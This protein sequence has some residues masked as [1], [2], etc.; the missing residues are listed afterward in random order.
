MGNSWQA[1]VAL[2]PG[3]H[4]ITPS[5]WTDV[6]L[7]AGPALTM[8]SNI[9]VSERWTSVANGRVVYNLAVPSEGIY[10]V[11]MVFVEMWH[12]VP[13]SR[14]FNV[15]AE[16]QIALTNFDIVSRAGFQTP[17]VEEIRVEVLDGILQLE[18]EP[19]VSSAEG[20]AIYG[21]KVATIV[22]THQPTVPP[23]APTAA[24][25]AP[26]TTLAPTSAPTPLDFH[27]VSVMRVNCGDARSVVDHLGAV[28]SDESGFLVSSTATGA[29]ET[30]A[31]ITFNSEV[32]AYEELY[33][34]ERYGDALE[35][36]VPVPTAGRYQVSLFL[37]ENW[38]QTAGARVFSMTLQGQLAQAGID[39]VN[40]SGWQTAAVVTAE[41]YVSEADE[42]LLRIELFRDPGSANGIA[43][44]AF[45]VSLASDKTL[46]VVRINAAG[47]AV[48]DALG[49]VW[50]SDAELAPGG[51]GV[52]PSIYTDIGTI[53]AEATSF[54]RHILDNERWTRQEFGAIE[55]ILPAPEAGQYMLR[56]LTMEMWHDTGGARAFHVEVNGQL[57][58]NAVD[59]FAEAGFQQPL[60]KES[61]VQV[62]APGVIEVKFFAGGRFEGPAIYAVT[63]IP[64]HPIPLGIPL[65]QMHY[66]DPW[67]HNGYVD[68]ASLDPACFDTSEQRVDPLDVPY[69]I[70][71][72]AGATNAIDY[73][74]AQGLAYN[75]K[76]WV[77]GGFESD[78]NAPDC[79]T[80]DGGP[81]RWVRQGHHTIAY[82]ANRDEWSR[83]T[84]IDIQGGLTHCGETIFDGKA[85]LAGGLL[86]DEGAVWPNTRSI[87]TVFVYDFALD[88]WS[89]LA[90]LP[91]ARAAGALVAFG[92][93]I[94]YFG[95]GRFEPYLFFVQDFSTHWYYDFDDVSPEWKPLAPLRDARN[96]LGG[97]AHGGKLYAIGG[98]HLEL[99]Y[100]DNRD[101][102]EMY[103]PCTNTWTYVAPLPEARGHITP[104]VVSFRE[105]IMVVGGAIN[106]PIHPGPQLTDPRKF[107]AVLF[108]DPVNDNWTHLD[109]KPVGGASQVSGVIINENGETQLITQRWNGSWIGTVTW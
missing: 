59:P 33:Y 93:R 95:G 13:G 97:A 72:E 60:V 45:D 104:S 5:D 27:W 98:Q 63:L 19:L 46:G 30:S 12:R 22:S 87:D 91:A 34:Y 37:A 82:D 99:E 29:A 89:R 77:F 78:A 53:P 100:T 84:D 55:Y 56:Y 4:S 66:G 62:N 57:V 23:T 96:H 24:P 75:S 25:T 86:M 20:P 10:A 40:S 35:Y 6:E 16:G 32:K 7:A 1:D 92:S 94:H 52:S 65:P 79:C 106:G 74:E 41:T 67:E 71:W 21:I 90:P 47:G 9:L 73:R 3:G 103:D 105:G 85:I 108:Y 54:Y 43:V 42:N 76:L 102:V 14:V 26:P 15:R 39:V 68:P 44:F 8:Y 38:H 31:I 58:H 101:T 109:A 88:S 18:L 107:D 48:Q 11:T 80:P 49:K 64:I 2:F 28:W 50:E 70:Q 81:I 61:L 36:V 17:L 69:S 51:R 83:H